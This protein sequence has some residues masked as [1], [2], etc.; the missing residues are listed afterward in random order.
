MGE[1]VIRPDN[2]HSREGQ[3]LP[4]VAMGLFLLDIARPDCLDGELP[5]RCGDERRVPAE[6]QLGVMAL[7]AD[8]F[9][10]GRVT[11]EHVLY[12]RESRSTT[13]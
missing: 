12:S 7:L 11:A 10:E 13:W 4:I 3:F 2:A 9:V 5:R 1:I 6:A 8:F